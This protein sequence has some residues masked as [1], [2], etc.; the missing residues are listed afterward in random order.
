MYVVAAL[1][2]IGALAVGGLTVLSAAEG[3]ARLEE[4]EIASATAPFL[5]LVLL[6][7]VLG[8]IVFT[9]L[10]SWQLALR[11]GRPGDVVLW[12]DEDGVAMT[13]AGSRGFVPWHCVSS[14][15]TEPLLDGYRMRLVRD[16]PV[17]S[18]RDRVSAVTRLALRRGGMTFRFSPDDPT[19]E[20]LARSVERLWAG[21]FRLAPLA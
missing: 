16:G 4:A 12:F 13:D 10:V 3:V 19:H 21:R 1:G 9:S 5:Q 18:G 7:M 6:T 8:V 20:A 2:A 14:L 17:Q 11:P 15:T